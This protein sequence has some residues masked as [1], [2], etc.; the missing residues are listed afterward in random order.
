MHVA[1]NI[2]AMEVIEV[3]TAIVKERGAPKH[4]RS[5]NGPEFIAKV[6]K[7]LDL[8]SRGI[9]ALYIEPGESVG[10]CV[11]RIVQRTCGMDV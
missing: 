2:G 8:E 10:E 9:A 11:L 4:L 6:S 5:D 3:L 7:T 1:R